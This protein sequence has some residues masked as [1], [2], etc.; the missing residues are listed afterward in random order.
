MG[1]NLFK[2]GRLPRAEYLVI[3]EELRV[4]LDKKFAEDYK[5][6]RYYDDKSDFGDADILLSSA[7]NKDWQALQAEIIN[8]LQIEDSIS[9]Q[10][11][12]STNYRQFQVDFFF[13]SEECFES[14][15]HFLCFNDLGNLLGKIFRRFNLKYGEKGLFY[16]FRRQEGNYKQDIL[17]SR[18]FSKILSFLELSYAE[19]D[20]GFGSLGELFRWVIDSPYFSVAPYQNLDRVTAQRARKRKTMRAFLDY[21]EENKIN[22]TYPFNEDRSVYFDKID[23][24]FPE[25]SLTTQIHAEQE[26]EKIAEQVRQRFNGKMIMALIPELKGKA[27]GEFIMAF[28]AQYQDFQKEIIELAPDAVKA[29]VLAFHKN[30]AS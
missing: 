9:Q 20:K 18:D 15:Y 26:K 25:A 22:K 7:I 8:D 27:L 24:F 28:K 19:W 30:N 1:G 5:I 3:E 10:R 13:I 23:Q 6:P 4:Y 12:L 21:I 2:L 16:V 14:S 29:A 17:L 11:L